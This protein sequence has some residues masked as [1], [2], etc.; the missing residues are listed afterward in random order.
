M[1][2]FGRFINGCPFTGFHLRRKMVIVLL[3]VQ[4]WDVFVEA[5]GTS[6]SSP[7]SPSSPLYHHHHCPPLWT[8]EPTEKNPEE[9]SKN[10]CAKFWTKIKFFYRKDQIHLR[11]VQQLG[12]GVAGH[13]L[14]QHVRL[15][16][17]G[18]VGLLLLLYFPILLRFWLGWAWLVGCNDNEWS[19][20]NSPSNC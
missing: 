6:S 19:H 8:S 18:F 10:T 4:I 14:R 11:C 2:Q 16:A 13:L 7:R 20:A 9:K 15:F 17:I 3:S 12:V 1:E 5:F